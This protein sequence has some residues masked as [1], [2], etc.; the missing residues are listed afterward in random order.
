MSETSTPIDI[1]AEFCKLDVV[2]A[3][4]CREFETR[5]NADAV[6]FAAFEKKWWKELQTL[7]VNAGKI[8][9]K[10]N[11]W[12]SVPYLLLS[13]ITEAQ[14]SKCL[15][16]PRELKNVT[17]NDERISVS[18][19]WPMARPE[20]P[21]IEVDS[22]T[23]A[24]AA[25]QATEGNVHG[26]I[27]PQSTPQHTADVEVRGPLVVVKPVGPS[28]IEDTTPSTALTEA[29]AAKQTAEDNLQGPAGP[30]PTPQ[31]T[32]DVE[33]RG[34][35][36]A[37]KPV[38]P[39]DVEDTT[40]SHAPAEQSVAEQATVTHAYS[41]G[42]PYSFAARG[43]FTTQHE[44]FGIPATEKPAEA[45]ERRRTELAALRQKRKPK[46][47][48]QP[49]DV[50]DVDAD[51][52]E[53]RYHDHYCN[54]CAI[55]QT[56]TS[57]KREGGEQ[58]EEAQMVIS[59]SP[60]VEIVEV[61]SRKG[62][63]KVVDVEMQEEGQDNAGEVSAPVVVQEQ[64]ADIEMTKE[65]EG[66]ANA[67]DVAVAAP[68][69]TT[70]VEMRDETT[71][72]VEKRKANVTTPR[73]R[74]GRSGKKTGGRCKVKSPEEVP[75]EAE[76]MAVDNAEAG[77]P[78]P[79]TNAEPGIAAPAATT[80]AAAGGS[81]QNA[82]IV[83]P[84]DE[85]LMD[86][87]SLWVS[88]I[89][90]N[91]CNRENKKICCS[92]KPPA[93]ESKFLGGDKEAQQ[94]AQTEARLQGE[95]KHVSPLTRQPNWEAYLQRGLYN[96]DEK[97]RI[98]RQW[99]ATKATEGSGKATKAAKGGG[100]ATKAEESMPKV[101]KSKKT[102]APKATK[103]TALPQE[104][105]S[106][107]AEQVAGSVDP[108]QPLQWMKISKKTGAMTVEDQ[109]RRTF[110]ELD[111][112]ANSDN[113]SPSREHETTPEPVPLSPST[114]VRH[115]QSDAVKHECRHT[116]LVTKALTN[117]MQITEGLG[118]DR[119]L[120]E[121]FGDMLAIPRDLLYLKCQL[122]DQK[123]EMANMASRA[124]KSARDAGKFNDK[125]DRIVAY[126]QEASEML[127]KVDESQKAQKALTDSQIAKAL[128]RIQALEEMNTGQLTV[129]ETIQ[130]QMSALVL[131]N[132]KVGSAG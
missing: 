19:W 116:W 55:W 49:V 121:Q 57:D 69:K 104:T 28:V 11:Q 123:S 85:D 125:L 94:K 30:E 130:Q 127:L 14:N 99:K 63:K 27:P 58:G 83:I 48:A 82:E 15:Q 16:L 101:T 128:G 103:V 97:A 120:S 109:P 108:A 114:V 31:L 32:T 40:Q 84:S 96:L 92:L 93:A 20:P 91:K 106:P 34:P 8:R 9:D 60:D 45:A 115:A 41:P 61:M 35:L 77:A 71:A 47:Q 51:G 5:P 12:W 100:K 90:C 7:Y 126:V 43:G 6:Q 89:R 112:A 2:A 18:K 22:S 26:S 129:V 53:A 21:V 67:E 54:A 56:C 62:K 42:G 72:T 24:S 86:L 102:R 66:N 59:P 87:Y 76:A 95:R 119:D 131:A 73:A 124:A 50:I 118:T 44:S 107:I 37:V 79:P 105:P 68:E 122:D 1:A 111:H 88:E 117:F 36:I 17:V 132:Q 70:D 13:G 29:S 78:P 64:A 25:Q 110:F 39:S 38:G 46:A 3:R 74:R 98:N 23:Q 4:L 52:D 33:A 113:S 10:T 80:E 75:E 65:A 81:S